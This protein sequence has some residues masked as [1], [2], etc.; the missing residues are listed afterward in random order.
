MEGQEAELN[1][2]IDILDK[3]HALPYVLLVGSWVEIVYARTGLLPG[4]K[5]NIRTYAREFA[6]EYRLDII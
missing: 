1:R 4:F 6:K 5:A 2:A 3:A